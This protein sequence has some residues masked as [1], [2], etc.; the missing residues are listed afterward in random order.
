MPYCTHLPAGIS[1]I[2]IG[3]EVKFKQKKR[4]K[5]VEIMCGVLY[6]WP[7]RAITHFLRLVT[8]NHCA[9][10]TGAREYSHRRRSTR[11]CT[12]YFG[13]T[14]LR[15]TMA[16]HH[17]CALPVGRHGQ[18]IVGAKTI[19]PSESAAARRNTFWAGAGRRLTHRCDL[20]LCHSNS[21]C[22]E[23]PAKPPRSALQ[24]DASPLNTA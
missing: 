22:N 3:K 7:P 16:V 8:T 1:A 12:L 4:L 2:V 5:C 19:I 9:V 20:V 17:E 24:R 11:R 14:Q 13:F 21:W 15:T 18:P 6:A 23:R 10:S